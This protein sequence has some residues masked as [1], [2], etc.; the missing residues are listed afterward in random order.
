MKYILLLF[1]SMFYGQTLH[2]QMIS[3]QGKSITLP[4]GLTVSHSIAQLSVN[5]SSS[6]AITVQQGFQQSLW[7]KY[8]AGNDLITES[9]KVMVYPNPF[10]S[11]V[12]FEFVKTPPIV[13]LSIFDL[14]GRLVFREQKNTQ[15]GLVTIDLSAL[16]NA[17]YLIQLSA[18]NFNYY[19]K[20][21][22]NL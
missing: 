10:V 21:I 13:S 2:H 15:N 8:I 17:S 5:G 14:T 3:S 22:K 20:I 19:T 1:S 16:P 6:S 12:N 4:N 7:S 11:N 18:S 9:I